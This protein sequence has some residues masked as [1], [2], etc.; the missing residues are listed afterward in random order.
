M[1]FVLV[2]VKGRRPMCYFR[3]LVLS[4]SFLL[5]LA[6][7]GANVLTSADYQ[8]FQ[9]L[10]VKMLSVGDDLYGLVTTRAEA[11]AP[12]CL[13]QLAFKF[14]AVQADLHRIRS[15]V[16]L[17]GSMT[18]NADEMRVI[19]QLNLA[20]WGFVEQLKYHRLILSGIAGK[21]TEKDVGSKAQEISRT[22]N[23]AAA[24]IQSIIKKIGAG[25]P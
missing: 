18:D 16:G 15:L 10:D 6:S 9:D 22:W 14:D 21:C 3:A 19:R 4:L 8:S 25:S 11:N 12:D 23:E 13:I 5:P 1:V 20:A 24:L 7:A 2:L 17:A